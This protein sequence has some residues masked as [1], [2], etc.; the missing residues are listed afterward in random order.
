M[1]KIF[2]KHVYISDWIVFMFV[3][4]QKISSTV[5]NFIEKSGIEIGIVFSVGFRIGNR[6]DL[7]VL[8][9]FFTKH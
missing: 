4:P 8:P 5:C 9:I 1:L 3:F 7:L 2:C 6:M